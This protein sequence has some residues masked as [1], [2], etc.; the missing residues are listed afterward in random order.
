MMRIKEGKE[1]EYKQLAIQMTHM[2]QKEDE[3][4]IQYS[5]FQNKENPQEFML[6][7]RW[8]DQNAL[9]AHFKHLI[10]TFGPPHPGDIFPAKLVDLVESSTISNY[11]L[12]E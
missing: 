2:T 3:G 10:E 6:L 1:D 12:I 9:N 7:E 4:C 5:I 11:D 8:T